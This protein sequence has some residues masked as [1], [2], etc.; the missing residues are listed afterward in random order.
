VGTL[1]VTLLEISDGVF[2]V[3]ATAGDVHLG[4]EDI[5]KGNQSNAYS[6]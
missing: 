6:E 4:G 2:E 1:D 3:K 5:D